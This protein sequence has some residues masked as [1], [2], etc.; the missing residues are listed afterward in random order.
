[1]DEGGANAYE[2]EREARLQANRQKL[3]VSRVGTAVDARG[4]RRTERRETKKPLPLSL[5]RLPLKREATKRMRGQR[6]QS[7]GN[8][9]SS[10]ASPVGARATRGPENSPGN[11][12]KTGALAGA[13]SAPA[14]TRRR[15]LKKNANSKHPRSHNQPPK[16]PKT[17]QQELGLEDQV[18]EI[19]GEAKKDKAAKKK[20]HRKA[21]ARK[22][23]EGGGGG[24]GECGEAA[25]RRKSSREKAPVNYA[26]AAGLLR[27]LEKK[28]SAAAS[29]EW[30]RRL[31]ELRALDPETAERLRGEADKRRAKAAAKAAKA[32]AKADGADGGA[33]GGGAD[34]DEG[35]AGGG[36]AKARRGPIDSGK[37]VRIQ[38]GKVYDSALGVTCHWCRQKTLED[39]V[40]CTRD[41]CGGGRRLPVSFCKR[42]LANRH[43]ECSDAAEASGSWVCPPCRGSCG[44]GC[45]ACCNCG[46]CR[47]KAG[48]EP[49]H[50]VKALAAAA[51]FADVHDYLV[52]LVTGE[53][54]EVVR[55][56]KSGQWWGSWLAG[57]AGG[58]AA[59]AAAGR[60][61]AAGGGG[62]GR[63]PRGGRARAEEEEER[64]AAEKENAAAA[65]AEEAEASVHT[66]DAGDDQG[67]AEEVEQVATKDKAAAEEEDGEQEAA[68]AAGGREP[69]PRAAAAPTQA[70]GRG[71]PPKAAAAAAASTPAT[72]GKKR[73]RPSKA[74]AAAAPAAAAAAAEE[75]HEGED[76]AEKKK[77]QGEGEGEGEEVAGVVAAAA[78]PAA[79]AAAAAAHVEKEDDAA[80]V[81]DRKAARRLAALRASGLA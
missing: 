36:D 75:D 25:E 73:G 46:P 51:G 26:E 72:T 67:A 37:G 30:E 38:G 29:A 65:A 81:L 80:V 24:E 50:Q 69:A 77:K 48:L 4:R 22:A 44:P 78:E 62:A 15:D 55:G 12:V 13:P 23:G 27:A 28:G 11:Q 79:K 42:C 31:E 49:T 74:A 63:G 19:Q 66:E 18:A 71:R 20:A 60:G 14:R 33:D 16:R 32:A 39:H 1:M 10:T 40:T 21:A 68:A 41:G 47:K 59:A 45:V 43:G 3:I 76:G 58:G 5:V 17:Q 64:A 56:R 7:T 61:A 52:H 2:Q 57:A 8:S 9:A 6:A 53:G 35:A 54:A 70:K 34:G